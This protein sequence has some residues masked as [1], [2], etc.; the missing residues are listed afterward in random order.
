MKID[1]DFLR[2]IID[3]DDCKEVRFFVA[4]NLDAASLKEMDKRDTLVIVGVDSKGNNI[5]NG[6]SP[7]I[8]E[9]LTL[10]PFG[11]PDLKAPDDCEQGYKR[12]SRV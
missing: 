9:D 8:Y 11:C 7:E 12:R 4:K 3:Q 10:C 5:I 1:A 2:N 6:E